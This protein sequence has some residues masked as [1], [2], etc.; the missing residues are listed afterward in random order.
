MEEKF[1]KERNDKFEEIF[2]DNS[3]N[4]LEQK[5]SLRKSK[6]NES[7]MS[8]RAI[9]LNNKKISI[10][11][12]KIDKKNLS[13]KIL[14]LYNEEKNIKQEDVQIIILKY[15]NEL[16]NTSQKNDNDS[17]F[18]LDRILFIISSLPDEILFKVVDYL[19]LGHKL[20]DIFENYTFVN[21]IHV[22]KTFKKPLI[23]RD[24]KF[25][26]GYNID[27]NIDKKINNGEYKKYIS[28]N[29]VEINKLNDEQLELN[30]NTNVVLKDSSKE[31]Y[32][33]V[34][35]DNHYPFEYGVNAKLYYELI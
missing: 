3:Y 35:S 22:Y 1:F 24:N 26:I 14:A 23:Q 9:F 30:V 10:Y 20:F 15:F 33:F 29:N 27:E 8:K 16:E 12:P 4:K 6:K 34:D 5:L 25:Y 7:L 13:N 31:L 32:I 11:E 17:Y 18:I 21:K 19:S 28:I 2:Q